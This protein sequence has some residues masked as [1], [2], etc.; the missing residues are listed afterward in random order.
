MGKHAD[1][2]GLNGDGDGV[3]AA[4][5]AAAERQPDLEGEDRDTAALHNQSH[6]V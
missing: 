5:C 3:I 6:Q 1:A 2:S 4:G